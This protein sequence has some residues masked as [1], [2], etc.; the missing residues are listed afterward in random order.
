MDQ[1][2]RP[3]KPKSSHD[4]ISFPS[5]IE[6]VSCLQIIKITSDFLTLGS[7][8]SQLSLTRNCLQQQH[9]QQQQQQQHFQRQQQYLLLYSYIIGVGS[10]ISSCSSTA[11]IAATTF[12]VEVS[13]AFVAAAKVIADVT[14]ALKKSVQLL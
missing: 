11:V 4:H 14:E 1:L 3:I 6:S 2:S 8:F 12:I 7:R 9:L 13:V 10:S 5:V